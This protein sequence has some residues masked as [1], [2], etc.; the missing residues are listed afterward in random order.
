MKKDIKTDPIFYRRFSPRSFIKKDIS[1][2]DL[3]ALFD[4][5]RW[6]ASSY[7]EQPWRFLIGRKNQSSNYD[8]LL[9]CLNK[10]NQ[11]WADQAPVLILTIAKKTFSKDESPNRHA[12][13]DLGL[14]MGN[15]SIQACKFGIMIHQMA[16]FD[17]G[18]AR[19]LFQLKEDFE[20][21]SIVAIGYTDE[22]KSGRNRKPLDEI[23]LNDDASPNT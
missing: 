6:A 15:F 17:I 22:V 18:K 7:N 21:V 5:A 4:A 11:K 13:H 1:K 12:L 2:D 16:G 23:I 3:H 19:S 9:S 14:A 10:N 8:L 20:P